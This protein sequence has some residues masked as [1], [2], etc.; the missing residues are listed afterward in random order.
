VLA[1]LEK[2]R[3]YF[4]TGETLPV[5]TRRTCLEQ[6]R[7]AIEA[8]EGEILSALHDD[9]KKSPQQA[10]TTEVGWVL[11]DIKHALSGL[12]DWVRPS[13]ARSP[14]MLWP[15]KSKVLV[16]PYG[17][18]LILGPW[19][20]PFQ[21]L[22]SPWVSA[23]AAGNCAVLKPSEF[24]PKTAEVIARMIRATFPPEFV[25]VVM[26][27]HHVAQE[28]LAHRF[29]KI[30]FTGGTDV[31]K[32]VMA[33]AA[34]HL[35]PVTLELGG[36]SPCIV[37]A[38]ADIKLAARRIAWGKFMNA[39]QTCVAPDHVWV[40]RSIVV[41]F[42]E[43]IKQVLREFYGDDV[44]KSPDYGR[45]I[46]ERQFDRL[47]SYLKQGQAVIG[48]DHDRES[49]FIAPA[50]LTGVALESKLMQEEI[51][52]PILPLM[53]YQKIDDVFD[54]IGN[55]PVPL[56]LYLFTGDRV[57]QERV[58]AK[59]RS[60]GVCINDTMSHMLNRNLPFGGLGESGMGACHGKAGFDAFSYRRSVMSR[61]TLVDL[62]FRYPPLHLALEK[63]KQGLKW[64]GGV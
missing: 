40:D 6:L 3:A 58:I 23:I 62:S 18:A 10:Y 20:Y 57:L 41:P 35:T 22:L 28:L 49:L 37:A 25:E 14:L 9:L 51:F 8:H 13:H 45:I 2:Q 30:F 31:G 7:G 11:G 60:G 17:V 50:V 44:K 53:E 24:A 19:N 39:G 55:N 61:S 48:G 33:A 46:H 5:A 56:A 1:L 43:A 15:A 42:I 27:D 64:L 32:Q 34:R 36:K 29:D 52:G 47:I 26:G 16:E 4:R 59:T 38:D 54:W 12:S 63:L 21:L